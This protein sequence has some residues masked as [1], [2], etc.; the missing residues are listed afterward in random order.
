MGFCELSIQGSSQAYELFICSEKCTIGSF[1]FFSRPS[2]KA[3]RELQTELDRMM[4]GGSPLAKNQP[5][6]VTGP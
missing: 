5:E 3:G 6:P 4:E 2:P 1:L